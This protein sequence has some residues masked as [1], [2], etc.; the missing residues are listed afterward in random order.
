[1]HIPMIKK[2]IPLVTS[3]L[4]YKSFILK[5]LEMHP[6]SCVFII[7]VIVDIKENS[8]VVHF[9]FQDTR[10]HKSIHLF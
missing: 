4:H 2:K 5:L 10:D 7:Q 3:A 6:L 9:L 1:M 8:K